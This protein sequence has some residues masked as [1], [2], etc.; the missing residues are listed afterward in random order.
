[1]LEALDKILAEASGFL[2]GYILLFG[3]LGT[4]LYLTVVLRFPQLYFFKALRYY[5]GRG[6]K[7]KEGQISNFSSLMVSLAA[8]VGTGNIVGVAVAVATGG[9]GAVFW[10]MVTG[11]LGMATRYAES[12]LA[13]R[14]RV[15]DARGNIVGGPMYALERGLR[16]KWLA[17]LFAVFTAIA[18][19]GIG[20]VTQANAVSQVLTESALHVPGWLTGVLLA[21]LVAAVLIG[22]LKGISRV[23]AACVPTM[24]LVYVVGC[25]ILLLTHADYVWPAI[26]RICDSAFTGQAAAGGFIGSTLMLAMQTGVRRGL[27]SNEAG[28]G[29][30]PIISAPVRTD[31]AVQ[32]ALVASTGPF[33]DTVVICSLTGLTLTTTVMAVPE[34]TSASG[35]LLTYHSFATVGGVGSAMLTISLA[36]FVVSTVLGWSYFGEKALQYLGG[37]RLILPYRV[38]WVIMAFVG[39]V[40]PKSS[41]VWNFADLTNGLMALPNLIC[42]VGM[43]GV[44]ISQ[45]RYYLWQN[46]LDEVD[47]T[48]IPDA[49]MAEK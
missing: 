19:F 28:M 25:A 39:C 18:A 13:I 43:S 9:P 26:C 42:M 40:I 31:N 27:F 29:S 1:M 11:V 37:A 8:N 3:L 6:Q 16:C 48:P 10:C 30:S 5:A 38:L 49:D 45:T 36:A 41:I 20:N 46:R 15:K 21:G 35:E 2:W 17:V 32:Q 22:G 44:L 24:A 34:V 12:L 23:C 47:K 4:H 14:Y 33:W 7:D